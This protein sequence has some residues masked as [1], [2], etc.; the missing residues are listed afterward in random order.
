MPKPGSDRV[1]PPVAEVHLGSV[2]EA[3]LSGG[4]EAI[5]GRDEEERVAVLVAIVHGEPRV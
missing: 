5:L 3:E 4:L 1:S 2:A